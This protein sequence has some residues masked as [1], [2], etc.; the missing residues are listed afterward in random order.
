M[1][2]VGEVPV[3][4][5][6]KSVYENFKYVLKSRGLKDLEIEEKLNAMIIEYNLEMFRDV[7]PK[8]LSLYEKYVISLLRLSLR[9]L[10]IVLI[11]DI[12]TKVDDNQKQIIVQMVKHLFID[13]KVTTL[14]ASN[15]ETLLKGV[16]KKFY[17]FKNGSI[18]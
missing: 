2:Y 7:K 12:F 14:V 13:K 9:P 16:C 3:F 15:D 8:D 6:N 17:H 4:L 18:D 1:G 11:D 5:E 10:D